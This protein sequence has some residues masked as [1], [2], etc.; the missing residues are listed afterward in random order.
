[1]A[2]ADIASLV[3]SAAAAAGVPPALAVAQAQQ[4]SG[5]NPAAYNPGSG[6]I[7]VMQL[8]PATAADLGVN[9]QDTVQNIQ[10]GVSYLAQLYNQFGDWATALAAYDWGPG[11]VTKAIAANGSDFL[12][13]APAETQN[14]VSTILAN[15]GMDYT[16]QVTPASVA[17]GVV[18][19]A[20]DGVEPS[21]V[22]LLFGAF[23]VYFLARFLF[24]NFEG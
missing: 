7:G 15:A 4:E 2:S 1:M 13:S 10:G 5:L 9:P 11:N 17:N 24:Q 22:L 21:L 23:G 19:A 16:A 6:A 20:S 18:T 12:D 3:A 8:E 14:Y